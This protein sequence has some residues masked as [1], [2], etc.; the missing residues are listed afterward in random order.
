MFSAKN[1]YTYIICNAPFS[2]GLS[3][4]LPGKRERKRLKVLSMNGCS[5]Y[6]N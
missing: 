1:L 6:V 2:E 5:K 3:Q 4:L